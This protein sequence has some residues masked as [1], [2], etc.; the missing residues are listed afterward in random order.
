MGGVDEALDDD[1]IDDGAAGVW[2]SGD[3]LLSAVAVAVAA[4]VFDEI[5]DEEDEDDG[6]LNTK[7]FRSPTHQAPIRCE[8]CN[9]ENSI[10]FLLKNEKAKERKQIETLMGI[11]GNEAAHKING[12]EV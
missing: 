11:C 4:F 7:T 3:E 12:F 10:I 9:W 5:V 2:C 8:S 6:K 1:V